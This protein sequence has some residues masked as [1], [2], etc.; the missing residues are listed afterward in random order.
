MRKAADMPAW[1]TRLVLCLAL[2]RAPAAWLAPGL[3]LLALLAGCVGV[4]HPFGI[5]RSGPP[6]ALAEIIGPSVMVVPLA[7]PP[8]EIA[9]AYADQVAAALARSDV[10]ASTRNPSPRSHLLSGHAYVTE[11]SGG[12]VLRVVWRLSEPNGMSAGTTEFD[13]DLPGMAAGAPLAAL[14]EELREALARRTA[15]W[16]AERLYGSAATTPE[17]ASPEAALWAK[18]A[19]APP[20]PPLAESEE[21][22]VPTIAA[23]LRQA[24]GGPGAGS[25]D[26]LAMA[27]QARTARAAPPPVAKPVRSDASAPAR[28][29]E[30]PMLPVATSPDQAPD[31]AMA[32]GEDGKGHVF[33]RQRASSVARP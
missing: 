22:P 17:I 11:A 1:I 21:G 14:P 16:V 5:E 18:A 6:A 32:A 30:P 28:A 23:V 24:R 15:D 27:G 13:A 25:V 7:G 10:L 19:A 2:I 31:G 33:A 9:R 12:S 8:A 26:P 29:R 4:S 20:L 3:L